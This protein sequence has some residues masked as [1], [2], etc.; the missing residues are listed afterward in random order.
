MHCQVATDLDQTQSLLV[1]TATPGTQSAERLQLLSVVAAQ[2]A[3]DE[4]P[5]PGTTTG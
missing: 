1:F 2:P 4:S 3:W 5:V